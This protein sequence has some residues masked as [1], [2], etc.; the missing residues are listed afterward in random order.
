VKRKRINL[1][2]QP[3][4]PIDEIPSLRQFFFSR[5][6]T[7]LRLTL[8]LEAC[9]F[10]KRNG[11]VIFVHYPDR[12]GRE[13]RAFMVIVYTIESPVSTRIHFRWPS[14]TVLYMICSKYFSS[15]SF[16]RVKVV[17]KMAESQSSQ[18]GKE[19]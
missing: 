4:N 10:L 9:L 7:D 16:Q 19:A 3:T 13:S 18:K 5:D 2:K 1:R 6:S 12:F 15:F 11:K 14:G 17:Y 8:F